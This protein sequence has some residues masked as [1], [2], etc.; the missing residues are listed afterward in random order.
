MKLTKDDYRGLLR[1][2]AACM[3]RDLSKMA[4]ETLE[5][6]FREIGWEYSLIVVQEI[7]SREHVPTNIYGLAKNIYR[8]KKTHAEN[9]HLWKENWVSKEDC[10]TP[11]EW[12]YFW[13]I[14]G[15]ILTW[16]ELHLVETNEF[17]A[18]T[19]IPIEVY[20]KAGN[21][22]SWSPVVDHLLSGYYSAMI[23]N[24]LGDYLERYY[25]QLVKS[26]KERLP[27]QASKNIAQ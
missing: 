9:K 3:G 17:G 1:E 11:Q 7:T 16:H 4:G 2:I 26:R 21:P 25:A 15:E 19:P 6:F 24:L 23:G 5:N 27:L 18:T 22:Q 10:T 8:E 13:K 14:L 20:K 12:E